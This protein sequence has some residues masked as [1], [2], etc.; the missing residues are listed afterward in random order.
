MYLCLHVY[1]HACRYLG[2][3]LFMYVHMYVCELERP[4]MTPDKG[5]NGPYISYVE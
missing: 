1:K 4:N 3:Y 2:M 5:Y